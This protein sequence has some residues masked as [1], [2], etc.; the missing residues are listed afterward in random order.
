MLRALDVA[1]SE[2]VEDEIRQ[3][4]VDLPTVT[5]QLAANRYARLIRSIDEESWTAEQVERLTSREVGDQSELVVA[6]DRVQA[7]RR[8]DFRE[9]LADRVAGGD[10]D[11]LHSYGSVTDLPPSAVVGMVSALASKVSECVAAARSGSFGIGGPD[12][13]HALVLLNAWHPGQA[14][15][16]TCISALSEPALLGEHSVGAVTLLGRLARQVPA[17]VA[18]SLKGPLQDMS[19]RKPIEASLR[20]FSN[21]VDPR[22]PA[23]LTLAQLFPHEV[24]DTDLL[25]LLRGVPEERAAAV[26]LVVGAKRME[27]LS[28]MAALSKDHDAPVRAAVAR[29]LA[30]WVVDGTAE[31]EAVVLLDE[32]LSEP[33]TRLG[34]AAST[35]LDEESVHP[36]LEPL[37]DRLDA[38]PSAVVR[39]RSH[40]ARSLI[41]AMPT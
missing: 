4:I 9:S 10:L 12:V 24:S 41:R 27:L 25:R 20:V 38:H 23:T 22:G 13:L 15:W 36:G 3:H 26:G 19:T 21:P 40:R 14:D 30:E 17:A 39:Y 16:A 8:P 33:G 2:T 5:D 31:G 35:A 7:P 11:A 6:I 29:G 1:V 32:L 37:L 28:L 18:D 34:L